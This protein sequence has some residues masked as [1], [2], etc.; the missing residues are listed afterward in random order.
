M[1]WK[2]WSDPIDHPAVIARLTRQLVEADDALRACQDQRD[3]LQDALK[4]QMAHNGELRR[5]ID[6]MLADD[7][8]AE[9]E[10]PASLVH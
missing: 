8:W 9:L 10:R 5:L 1:R 4:V 7:P 6:G 2:F 3:I